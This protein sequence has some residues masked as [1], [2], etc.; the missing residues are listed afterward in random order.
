MFIE[1]IPDEVTKFFIIIVVITIVYFGWQST[2][3]RNTSIG[4]LIIESNAGSLNPLLFP[5]GKFTI[6]FV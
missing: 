3:T 5:E 1:S 6:K 4:V 2:N